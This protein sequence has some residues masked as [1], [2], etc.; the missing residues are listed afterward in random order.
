MYK[1]SIYAKIIIGRLLVVIGTG[2]VGVKVYYGIHLINS[3]INLFENIY[4]IY[5]LQFVFSSLQLPFD[6]LHFSYLQ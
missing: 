3:I 6:E 1:F 4:I 2:R 5:N